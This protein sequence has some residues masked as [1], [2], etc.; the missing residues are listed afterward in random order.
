MNLAAEQ[1]LLAN[2]KL[3]MPGLEKLL[4]GAPTS[5]AFITTASKCSARSR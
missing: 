5:I 3:R 4:D 1:Q 2:L